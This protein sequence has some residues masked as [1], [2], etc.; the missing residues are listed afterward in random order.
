MSDSITITIGEAPDPGLSPN[1]RKHHMARHR[2]VKA[3]RKAAY[4]ETLNGRTWS[5][6]PNVQPPLALHILIAWPSKRRIADD[7]NAIGSAKAYR[8]GIADAMGVNDRDMRVASITQTVDDAK[9]GY[10][11]FVLEPEAQP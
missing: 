5:E 9:R 7:D 1:A 8:D 3:A 2:L 11:K 4:F 6:M 10:M